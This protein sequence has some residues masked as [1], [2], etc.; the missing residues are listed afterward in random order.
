MWRMKK[1]VMF[2]SEGLHR[3]FLYDLCDVS[4]ARLFCSNANDVV[5]HSTALLSFREAQGRV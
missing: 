4:H 2:N 3:P 1:E 5:F